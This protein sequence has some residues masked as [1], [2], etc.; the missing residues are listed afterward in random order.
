MATEITTFNPTEKGQPVIEQHQHQ[1]V[2]VLDKKQFER[3]LQEAG[4]FA[5]FI[6]E[7]QGVLAFERL[8]RVRQ[9]G[10]HFTSET[11]YDPNFVKLTESLANFEEKTCDPLTFDVLNSAIHT[12][13]DH[14]LLDG[15][16][17]LVAGIKLGLST[18]EIKTLI[19]GGLLHD[20]G[21][22]ALSHTGEEF[23]V[24]RGGVDHEKRTSIK[25]EKDEE[26]KKV[27]TKF[28]IDVGDVKQV[29]DEK[30]KL[31]ALQKIFDS[32]SYLILDCKPI[33]Q[34]QNIL[35]GIDFSILKDSGIKLINDMVGIN[36]VEDKFVLSIKTPDLWQKL[37]DIRAWMMQNIYV[38]PF[39]RMISDGKKQLMQLM[40][41]GQQ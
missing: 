11:P 30:G 29:I 40:L 38:H 3:Y 21:H 33:Y 9:L 23:I 35:A 17:A 32:L 4:N 12:R 6:K 36:N 14:S 8:S 22:S 28:G 41:V 39:T 26:L 37:L 5:E 24:D 25:L 34:K 15:E 1:L 2:S 7:I 16:I 20:L 13:S 31:G 18:E 19:A 27:L 10:G